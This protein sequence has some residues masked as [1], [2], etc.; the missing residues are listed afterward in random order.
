MVIEDRQQTGSRQGGR[1]LDN[2]ATDILLQPRNRSRGRNGCTKLALSDKGQPW[3]RYI[4]ILLNSEC[5]GRGVEEEKAADW[6]T[7]RCSLVPITG[8]MVAWRRH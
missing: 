8:G 5:Y 4:C 1:Q 2:V 6:K 7:D 3:L